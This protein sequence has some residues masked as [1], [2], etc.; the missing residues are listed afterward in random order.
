M[1]N[2]II[3]YVVPATLL[4]C[5][6]HVHPVVVTEYMKTNERYVVMASKDVTFLP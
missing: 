3:L 6:F 5:K 4:A 1:K 2:V